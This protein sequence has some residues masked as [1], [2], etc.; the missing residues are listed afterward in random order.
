MKRFLCAVLALCMVAVFLPAG[1]LAQEYI[2]EELPGFLS[3]SWVNPLYEDL[4]TPPEAEIPNF[5]GI[6]MADDEDDI[7]F[8]TDPA[9]AAAQIRSG[10]ANREETV[11][12]GYQIPYDQYSNEGLY[13]IA[14]DILTA[15]CAHTGVPNQGDYL[16]WQYGGGS[17]GAQGIG[18]NDTRTGYNAVI[19]ISVQYYTDA[20]QEQ[21]VTNR[22][23]QLLKELNPTGTDYEKLTTVYNWIC[24]NV[25]YDN[26]HLED[27]DYKTQYTAYAALIDGTAVCQ[28]Y[29]LLLYRLALE[30]GIDCR[31]ITGI[32]ITATEI[33]G[34]AWN[35]L[36][37]DGKY[38]NVDATWDTLY[39]E[40]D[41]YAYYLQGEGIFDAD[42]IRD[43]FYTS[44]EFSAAYP[45]AAEKYTP[46]A[47]GDDQYPA[48]DINGD[49]NVDET[50]V[51]HLLWYTL[52]PDDY[53]IIGDADFNDD[54]NVD[55]DD[56]IYLLWHTLFPEDYPLN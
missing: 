56:V 38:Y 27:T 6:R 30:M 8:Y 4:I 53:E 43:G 11:F 54:G 14:M 21:A 7:V 32:G 47:G 2:P 25:V 40:N 26:D 3:G 37:L 20:A 52:F 44:A 33:G 41:D 51:I 50:D 1:V 35:I 28:G 16:E 9:A 13:V 18:H 29:A 45:M 49:T 12:V 42:H 24:D 48:G 34:H 19:S 36:K 39:A 5:Y 22:V 55:E 10:L 23:K 17:F 46:P 31:V 15:A